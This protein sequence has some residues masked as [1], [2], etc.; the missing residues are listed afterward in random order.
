MEETKLINICYGITSYI[1]IIIGLLSVLSV[2]PQR[3][4]KSRVVYIIFYILIAGGIAWESQDST[5]GFVTDL[6]MIINP[7]INLL[8]LKIF[9]K[10]C[11]R[12]SLLWLW[13]Y[14]MTTDLLRIP[15]L[16][17]RGVYE[18]TDVIHT[19]V[20]GGRNYWECIWNLL[21][22]FI[23][24]FVYRKWK[25]QIQIFV[26]KIENSWKTALFILCIDIS[27]LFLVMWMAGFF[28]GGY[29]SNF[30]LITNVLLILILLLLFIIYVFRS[31]YRYNKLE[32]TS[33]VEQKEILTK[34]YQFIRT[35][36]ELEAKRLHEVK[37]TYL[38]LLNCIEKGTLESAKE[39]LNTHLENTRNREWKIWTGFMDLDCILNYEYERM[40]QQKIKFTQKIELYKLPVK[41]EDMMIIMGNLLENAMEASMKCQIEERRIELTI[42]Q[43]NEIV[44]L[45]VK[46]SISDTVNLNEFQSQK[47][48]KIMHGWGIKNIKQIVDE[49]HGEMQCACKDGMF[50]VNII[51]ME[52]KEYE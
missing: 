48:D 50:D 26:K 21:I 15:L 46:N 32:K 30:N 36:C 7:V 38:Y 47:A 41:G 17:I 40:Q 43:I 34:E 37:H 42:Q 52:D 20:L 9:Y 27:A 8:L 51:F 25:T 13:L 4:W 12:S 1:I 19:N 39:C 2:F 18:K 45:D 6:Q 31:V 33:L 14:N 22:I 23:F 44:F 16:T 11:Y 49:N 10:I 3:R 29:Y 35:Y 5:R 24:I 28:D